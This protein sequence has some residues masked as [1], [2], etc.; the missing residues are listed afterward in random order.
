MS[1]WFF[2]V[3]FTVTGSTRTASLNVN[4]RGSEFKTVRSA[5][6]LKMRKGNRYLKLSTLPGLQ[7]CIWR[8]RYSPLLSP[9]TA[10]L[11]ESRGPMLPSSRDRAA[12]S[13][14]QNLSSLR[15]SSPLHKESERG[16]PD[17]EKR[18]R[19]RFRNRRAATTTTDDNASAGSAAR[20]D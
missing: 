9:W 10:G 3:S 7:G 18:Y 12:Q 15:N 5:D 11:T 8:A 16:N 14:S 13:A 1:T 20:A 4:V 6:L 2:R 19:T 17:T